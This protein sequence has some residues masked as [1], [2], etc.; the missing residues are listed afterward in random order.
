[1]RI[2]IRDALPDTAR[3][4]VD[5]ARRD[6][7]S[8]LESLLRLRMHIL[9][10]QLESQVRIAGVGKVDFV[11]AGRLVLE[12]DGKENHDGS[13]QRH[14]DL[15]RDAIASHLGFETLRFDYAQVLHDWPTVQ[16]AI[17]AALARV[18]G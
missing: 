10:V 3:W 6:A 1:M 15:R 4:L 2:R 11:I 18:V 9:G 16:A 5:V 12:V 8:G 17:L 14:K 7:D 13:T